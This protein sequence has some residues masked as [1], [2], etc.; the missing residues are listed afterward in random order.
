MNLLLYSFMHL[1]IY[2]F[3]YFIYLSVHLYLSIYLIIPL[4]YLYKEREV[5]NELIN[6]HE[7]IIQRNDFWKGKSEQ[8]PAIINLK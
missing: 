5:K 8:D 2:L 7:V 1:S 6:R 3:I 4:I